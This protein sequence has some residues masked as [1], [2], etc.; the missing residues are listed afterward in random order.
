MYA[1]PKL[2]LVSASRY[3][4]DVPLGLGGLGALFGNGRLFLINGSLGSVVE[5]L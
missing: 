2:A 1:A 4:C 3:Y 5:V